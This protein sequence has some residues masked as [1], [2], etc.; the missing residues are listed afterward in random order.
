[1]AFDLG[2]CVGPREMVVRRGL[3]DGC[4]PTG[5]MVWPWWWS[6]EWCSGE[7]GV[8]VVLGLASVLVFS[9]S[10]LG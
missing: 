4:P 2:V 10:W 9:L 1:M 6:D 3:G 5:L 7:G 8:A